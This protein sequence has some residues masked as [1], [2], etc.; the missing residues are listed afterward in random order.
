[1]A[2]SER[3]NSV[4]RELEGANIPTQEIGRQTGFNASEE[5][6]YSDPTEALRD[7]LVKT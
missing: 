2:V 7:R 6:R 4:G 1:M 3:K 5:Q